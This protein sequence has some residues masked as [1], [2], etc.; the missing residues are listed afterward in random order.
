MLH[1]SAYTRKV[2]TAMRLPASNRQR[3]PHCIAQQATTVMPA[4][5]LA[6]LGFPKL[7][8]GSWK[9]FGHSS[10]RTILRY[11]EHV[12]HEADL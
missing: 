3:N 5:P 2:F 4:H 1:L 9:L 11:S 8:A 12:P 7:G 10:Q 6:A